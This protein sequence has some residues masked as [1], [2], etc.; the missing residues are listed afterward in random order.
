M[1]EAA[2]AD[3]PSRRQLLEAQ[4]QQDAVAEAHRSRRASL[5]LSLLTL[6]GVAVFLGVVQATWFPLETH[7]PIALALVFGQVLVLVGIV[8]LDRAQV[9][10][11]QHRDWLTARLRAELLRRE[12]FLYRARVGPY[13]RSEKIAE[14]VADRITQICAAEDCLPLIALSSGGGSW[15][16]ALEDERHRGEETQPPE[17]DFW[18][19]YWEQRL[20]DQLR[21][22][23]RKSSHFRDADT[24]MKILIK[25]VVTI[26]AISSVV[27]ATLLWVE[28]EVLLVSLLSRTLPAVGGIVVA[29]RET[30]QSQRL[31]NAYHRNWLLLEE[32]KTRL[33]KL[34]LQGSPFHF[35]RLVLQTEAIL[36]HDLYEWW[37]VMSPV[38]PRGRD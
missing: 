25:A 15:Q 4:R 30:I 37:L 24:R 9:A 33:H 29:W 27:H 8:V 7:K 5:A 31:K 1:S 2:E 22:F 18:R 32:I 6:S 19:W 13:L 17:D 26:A 16:E 20:Q 35:K 12:A 36:S 21:Y 3:D 28:T 11:E 23:Q 10:E 14:A 34:Q 38:A